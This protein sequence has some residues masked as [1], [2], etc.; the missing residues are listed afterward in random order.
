MGFVSSPSNCFRGSGFQTASADRGGT[1]VPVAV[2]QERGS[3]GGD[4]AD[5]ALQFREPLGRGTAV[6]LTITYEGSDVLQGSQGRYAVGAR[7]SWYP[8]V[9]ILK[10][11]PR[12]R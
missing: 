1:P 7:D 6:K 10:T 2:L 8:N 9:G 5:V 12:T 4:A 3:V 11:L